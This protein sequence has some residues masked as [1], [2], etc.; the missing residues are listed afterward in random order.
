MTELEQ[1]TLPQQY[2]L[3]DAYGGWQWDA[4]AITCWRR[5]HHRRGGWNWPTRPTINAL[6]RMGLVRLDDP[7]YTR[8]YALT[9]D[10]C[11]VVARWLEKV[12]EAI[13]D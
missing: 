5:A 3:V 8:F 7:Y 12:T 13:G 11:A 10:G 9:T 6:V 4:R 2:A 1:L